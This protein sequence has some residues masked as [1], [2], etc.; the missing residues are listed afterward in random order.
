MNK[1]KPEQGNVDEL[2]AC[3]CCGSDRIINYWTE[4]NLYVVE[5]DVC[6]LMVA[7]QNVSA[8][9]KTWNTRTPELPDECKK[10]LYQCPYEKACM[11]SM[12]ECCNGCE[13]WAIALREGKIK[14]EPLTAKPAPKDEGRKG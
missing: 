4:N 12:E 9:E 10:T 5:C 14:Q 8:S 2:K 11:C 13:T 7:K 6:G 1:S 3:P